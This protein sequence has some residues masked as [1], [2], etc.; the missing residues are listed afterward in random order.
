MMSFFRRFRSSSVF[1]TGTPLS[2]WRSPVKLPKPEALARLA[3]ADHGVLSTIH[4]SRGIDSVPV[5][6]VVEGDRIGIPIDTVKPKSSTRLARDSN[7]VDDSRATLLV[8]HWNAG[9]W[10]NLW[11]VRVHLE[12]DLE[13]AFEISTTLSKSLAARYP[14][15]RDEPFE[16]VLV[17]RIN[18]ISGW[19]ADNEKRST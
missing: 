9:D 8:Q 18:A 3:A 17:F 13:P 19:A 15:Y 1:D 12:R 14:H 11:W 16:T 10:T 6:F 7:T 5:V 2:E 4:P